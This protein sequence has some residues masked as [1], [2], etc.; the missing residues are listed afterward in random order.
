M[1][2]P[3]G[4]LPALERWLREYDKVILD[5][6]DGECGAL[7]SGLLRHLESTG[8]AGR[9]LFLSPEPGREGAM[10]IPEALYRDLLEQYRRYDCS[11]RFQTLSDGGICGSLFNYLKTGLLTKEEPVEMLLR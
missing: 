4:G 6:P 8:R 10:C 1:R 9:V 2:R 3:D 7:L 5:G 11:D